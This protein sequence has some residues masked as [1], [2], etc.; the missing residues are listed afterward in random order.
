MRLPPPERRPRRRELEI[1]QAQSSHSKRHQTRKHKIETH[2]RQTKPRDPPGTKLPAGCYKPPMPTN[3]ALWLKPTGGGLHCEPGDFCIDPT[4]VVDRAIITHGHSDHAR[5][6]HTHVLATAETIA[7]MQARMGDRAG[8]SFQPLKYGEPLTINECRSASAPP[9]TCW[10]AP[11][12]CWNITAAEPWSAATTSAPPDPTCAR[13]E[14]VPCDVFVTEATFAL[15]VFRHPPP[16]GRNRPPA[17]QR[18]AVSRIV[19][20]SS[21]ATRWANASA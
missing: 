17:R 7:I 18:R 11:R 14:P 20:T 12:W 2:T 3:P 16:A 8:A 9:A 1:S 19:P 21:A 10:A 4:R 6:G 15:P 13:F 5:P